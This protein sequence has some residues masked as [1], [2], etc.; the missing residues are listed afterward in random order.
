MV[1]TLHHWK[2]IDLTQTITP[3]SPAY[4]SHEKC[5]LTTTLDYKACTTATKFKVQKITMPLGMGTHLDTPAHTNELGKTIEKIPLHDLFLPLIIIDCSN[6]HSR[7]NL[8]I[9]VEDIK[10]FELIHG[11][12][13]KKSFIYLFTGWAQYWKN[14]KKYRNEQQD[15]T[16]LHPTI[17][18]E[19]ID[20]LIKY[21]AK[22]IGIDTL[23][24]DSTQDFYAHQ[25]LLSANIMIVE[26]LAAPKHVPE[27]GAHIGIFPI[28]I[29]HT[30]ESPIRAIAFVKKQ[31]K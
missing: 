14:P 28:K 15:K 26:N 29:A 2:L 17:T 27:T 9:T 22:A 1:S 7:K 6:A 5:I 24:P 25:K 11:P 12:I 10:K 13:P 16:L 20:Q 30:T 18:K 31:K 19:V 8:K 23:S 3:T 4:E 21:K